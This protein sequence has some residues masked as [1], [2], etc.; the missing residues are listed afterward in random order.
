MCFESYYSQ[1]HHHSQFRFVSLRMVHSILMVHRWSYISKMFTKGTTKENK[2]KTIIKLYNFIWNPI[3]LLEFTMTLDFHEVI[4]GFLIQNSFQRNIGFSSG[5][6][7]R[8]N[9]PAYL[10]RWYMLWLLSQPWRHFY[11]FK[12]V[13]FLFVPWLHQ[14]GKLIFYGNQW[15]I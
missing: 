11:L 14:W 2:H 10:L 12:F 1:F 6:Q 15:I 3:S 4:T 7:A 5:S 8:T 13:N 9:T